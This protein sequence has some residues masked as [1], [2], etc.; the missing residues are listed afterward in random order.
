MTGLLTILVQNSTSQKPSKKRTQSS[1]TKVNRQMILLELAGL[2]FLFGLHYQN[3][4][5]GD[6]F[7]QFAKRQYD[8]ND[9]KQMH[10]DLKKG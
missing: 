6:V 8:Q 2:I 9:I 4:F 3:A 10:V 5:T 7:E 1:E